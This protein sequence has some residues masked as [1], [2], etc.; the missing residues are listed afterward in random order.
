[1]TRGDRN[2]G[3]G[4][5]GDA[6][7]FGRMDL[8]SGPY[9]LPALGKL[10]EDLSRQHTDLPMRLP[11]WSGGWKEFAVLAEKLLDEMQVSLAQA[12]ASKKSKDSALK[13][14][15]NRILAMPCNVQRGLFE[16]L[17]GH[18]VRLEDADRRDGLLDRGVVS[19]NHN[20]RWGRLQKVEEVGSELLKGADLSLR[21]LRLD[22]GLDF[23]AA[24]QWLEAAAADEEHDAQGFYL[25]PLEQSHPEVVLA[26]RRRR[27]AARGGMVVTYTLI[28]PHVGP[29]ANLVGQV[30]TLSRLKASA[31]WMV[32]LEEAAPLW[33]KQYDRSATQ[34]VHI[35]R[36][37]SCG[38]EHC[39]AGLRC[40]EET[41]LTGQILAHWDVLT[42]LLRQT[43]LVR[44]ELDNGAALVGFLV[45]T[46]S[47][48]IMR[49]TF[50]QRAEMQK[51]NQRKVAEMQRTM[52]G[53]D[54]PEQ[55]GP[56]ALKEKRHQ[57]LRA[58]DV[59]EVGSDGDESPAL[60]SSSESGAYMGQARWLP[61]PAWPS[62]IPPAANAVASEPPAKR[63]RQSLG[64]SVVLSSDSDDDLLLGVSTPARAQGGIPLDEIQDVEMQ[65]TAS[66]S[67]P[68]SRDRDVQLQPGESVDLESHASAAASSSRTSGVWRQRPT[69]QLPG[70]TL[71]LTL[72]LWAPRFGSSSRKQMRGRSKEGAPARS[73]RIAANPVLVVVGTSPKETD[74]LEKTSRGASSV[75]LSYNADDEI[76][77]M[78]SSRAR[79]ILEESHG[80]SVCT[81]GNALKMLGVLAFVAVGM[82]VAAVL[83][84]QMVQ[85]AEYLDSLGIAAHALILVL[86]LWSGFPIGPSWSFL[87][88]IAGFAFGWYGVLD[89][90]AGT[91]ISATVNFYASRYLI[92]AWAQRKIHGLESKKRLYLMAAKSV[93][94]MPRSGMLM[95]M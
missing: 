64:G 75:V 87:C 50:E 65:P 35:Q 20:S 81:L 62:G 10:S 32:P 13:K 77:T 54:R 36:G 29:S 24:K 4:A 48:R 17:A 19:L 26:L 49:D 74:D 25:R 83:G 91:Q 72:L 38:N 59:L 95:L 94:E 28:Y 3:L 34:C 42:G 92:A 55:R 58:K 89:A 14:F 7:G 93:M 16:L 60:S 69:V 33:H 15:L 80:S 57:K 82:V 66:S 67:V 73:P 22:R 70:L 53:R 9:G 11:G 85:V 37:R 90:M 61:A 44:C 88:A 8:M 23:E 18:V 46:D 1:M 79:T 86:F 21:K 39:R 27:A 5:S 84:K 63:Q 12:D 6:F 76:G 2:S 45:P 68:P 41:M 31:L 43:S 52:K 71:Q 30:C 51:T 40:L 56:R 78:D 47:V